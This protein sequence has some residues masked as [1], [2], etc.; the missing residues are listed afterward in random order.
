MTP[1]ALDY[2]AE[3][4]LKVA[5]VDTDDPTC[6]IESRDAVSLEDWR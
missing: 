2:Q 5:I 4:E 3:G 6:Y 1:T